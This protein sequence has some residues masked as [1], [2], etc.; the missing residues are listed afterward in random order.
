MANSDK[1]LSDFFNVFRGSRNKYVIHQPPYE[2]TENGKTKFSRVFYALENPRYKKDGE[3]PVKKAL[4]IDDFKEHLKGEKGVAVEPLTTA[5]DSKGKTVRNVCFYSVIDIDSYRNPAQFVHLIKRM[6]ELGLKFTACLSKSGGLHIY[7]MYKRYEPASSAIEVMKRVI[8][9]FGLDYIFCDNNGKSK[10]EYFPM[11]ATE[12]DDD[13]GKCVFLPYFGVASEQGALN[14]CLSINGK[15]ISLSKAIES[16]K[17]NYTSVDEINEAL[18]KLPYSDAPYCIQVIALTGLLGANGGRNEFLFHACVYLK[19]KFGKNEFWD[20]LLELD[21]CMQS[22][23]QDEDLAGVKSTYE[24]ANSKDWGYSCSK[25]P[26]CEYCNKSECKQR[27]YSGRSKDNARDNE[28]TGADMMGPISRVMTRV[29][30]YLWEIAAPGKEPKEVRFDDITELHN[31]TTVQQKCLDQLG[32]A[33]LPIKPAL[34][35]QKINDCM[36]GIENRQIAVDAQS[37]TTGLSELDNLLSNYLTHRQIQNGA[38][39]M[40]QVGQVFNS[41]GYLYF[42]TDGI[43]EFLR[44]ERFNLGRTNLREELLRYGCEEGELHYTS[45]NG[46]GRVIKCWKKQIDDALEEKMVFYEDIYAQDIDRAATIELAKEKLKSADDLDE[47][48]F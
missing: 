48:R 32:W 37:D 45:K 44:V 6:Y 22:P 26:Q 40:V 42:S 33:P 19:R 31:Q 16:F 47:D 43:K 29:P 23:L 34:W 14:K 27:E 5:V 10:V 1:I 21:R 46:I 30:Y 39:Y 11:H 3:E 36:E 18:D 7:F 28:N 24:S 20:E 2:K 41:D 25:S 12:N 38:A 35:I 15:T 9:V 17:D 8:T 13:N 4:T